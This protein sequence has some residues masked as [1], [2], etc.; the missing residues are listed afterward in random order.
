M[1]FELK[2]KWLI[3]RD[4]IVLYHKAF[5]ILKFHSKELLKIKRSVINQLHSGIK[6]HSNQIK[7]QLN[8]H[9]QAN[10]CL[11]HNNKTKKAC[12]CLRNWPPTKSKTCLST[13]SSQWLWN[14]EWKKLRNNQS[15]TVISKAMAQL[16]VSHCLS[17]FK[18]FPT[19]L[20]SFMTT[21]PIYSYRKP[22]IYRIEQGS[23]NKIA[24]FN[25]KSLSI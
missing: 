23:C 2:W 21:Q 25:P 3:D 19:K 12:K 18:L 6:I 9:Q 5:L 20:I 10:Q 4:Q 22:P 15:S 13:K 24:K 17:I 11:K 7:I 1:N 8:L 16:S 14:K